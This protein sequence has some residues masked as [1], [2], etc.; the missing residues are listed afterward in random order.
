[1]NINIFSCEYLEAQV[2]LNAVLN[3]SSHSGISMTSIASF[4]ANPNIHEAYK[5][6][7]QDVYQNGVK[8]A[9]VRQ[10]EEK[11]LEILR[12]Q[13]MMA[14]KCRNAGDRGQSMQAVPY[15]YIQP[16]NYRQIIVLGRLKFSLH[17]G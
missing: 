5:Q 7:C 8:R 6:A 17:S 13:G 12:S 3:I 2:Q 11:I 10:N 4:A 9:T 15:T 16:L 14:S 1:M